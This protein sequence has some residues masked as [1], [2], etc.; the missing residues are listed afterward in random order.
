MGARAVGVA[1]PLL[2]LALREDSDRQLDAWLDN[3][4]WTLRTIMLLAGG[5]SPDQLR[6]CPVV[7]TG[8]LREWLQVRGFGWFIDNLAHRRQ[9]TEDDVV[10]LNAARE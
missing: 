10:H 1:A 8:R 2:R 9:F 3:A 6:R 4:H 7:V 5:A